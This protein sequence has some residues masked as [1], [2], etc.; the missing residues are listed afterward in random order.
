MQESNRFGVEYDVVDREG[1]YNAD[2]LMISLGI[3]IRLL[4][5]RRRS[6][7]ATGFLAS[8]QPDVPSQTTLIIISYSLCLYLIQSN[9]SIYC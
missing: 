1:K 5:A 8:L 2:R 3:R 4:M 9:S 7:A 6:V